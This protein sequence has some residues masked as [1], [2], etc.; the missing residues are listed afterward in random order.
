MG[1]RGGGEV[2]AIEAP[3][4]ITVSPNT[5]TP[6]R[7]SYSQASPFFFSE[8]H[9]DTISPT[10]WRLHILLPPRGGRGARDVGVGALA[11][12]RDKHAG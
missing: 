10:R 2:P 1:G 11:Y 7:N 3:L 5:F 6:R 8:I 4:L 12:T 9:T